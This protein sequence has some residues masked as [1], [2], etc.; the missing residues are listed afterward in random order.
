MQK[1]ARGRF[2]CHVEGQDMRGGIIMELNE[3]T[4]DSEEIFSGKLIKVR[5]D[6]VSLPD[7]R[8]STREI[9]EHADAVAVIPVDNENN[10]WM[11]RQYRKAVEQVLLEIPAGLLEKNEDVLTGAQRELAEETGLRAKKWEKILSYYTTAGFSNEK[12]HIYLAGNLESGETN[13]DSDEFLE[14]VKVPL[15]QAYNYIFAGKIIDGK[16][17]I[18]IQYLYSLINK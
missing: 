2:V 11:V 5:V 13:P 1:V 12:I 18:G 14:V 4:L 8:E 15:Q 7:G 3:K 10:I 17:I 6:K 9:V 16:S